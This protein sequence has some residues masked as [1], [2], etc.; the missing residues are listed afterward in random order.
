MKF[1]LP[2]V[3]FGLSLFGASDAAKIEIRATTG[4]GLI[5]V[6]ST[7]Y[8][9]DDRIAYPLGSSFD[10]CRKTSYNW[11]KEICIDSD[12]AR[13]HIVYSGGTKKC[14][15]RTRSSSKL[16]GGNESCN[17]GVCNRCWEYDYTV[18]KC[19]W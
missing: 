17:K 18:V 7:T 6:S 8:I 5:P 14:F 11:I 13:A 4:P 9:G 19:T 15:K 16:C 10:G 12:R 2:A 3:V 1:S